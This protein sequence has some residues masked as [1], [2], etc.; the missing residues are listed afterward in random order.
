MELLRKI[1]PADTPKSNFLFLSPKEKKITFGGSLGIITKSQAILSKNEYNAVIARAERL[2][3]RDLACKWLNQKQFRVTP[4]NPEGHNTYVHRVNYCCK[5]RIDKSKGIGVH[6]NETRGKAH[7]SNLV[8]CGS[9]WTCADCGARI[10]EVRRT[11]LQQGI[12]NWRAK[13]GSVYLVTVTNRHHRG[14]NLKELLQGQK[15]AFIKLWEKYAVKQ[16]MKKLGY[17]GRI[18][19]CEVTWSYNNGWHPHFHILMFFDHQINTQGLQSFLSLEW[20]KACQKAGLKL[21]SLEHG[22]DVQDGTYADKYVAKWGLEHEMTKGH[23][24]KGR[25]GSLTPFDL[26]RQSVECPEYGK[27]FREFADAFKGKRQLTWTKGLKA[28]LQ[29]DEV[30]DEEIVEETEKDSVLVQELAF[31][32]F[33]LITLHKMQAE[34]LEAVELDWLDKGERADSLIMRLAQFEAG[35]IIKRADSS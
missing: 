22:V 32:L 5:R 26:L 16:M 33:Q 28:L 12:A 21:P 11:E 31:E 29:V 3:L 30:T 35:E 24:K 20:Q 9:V 2:T 19:A 13:G 7:F 23:V 25:E 27:L 8:H 14:D 34:Y 4:G 17:Q 6:I 18:V 15:L 1:Y 10:T